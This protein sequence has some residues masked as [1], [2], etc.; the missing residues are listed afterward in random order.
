MQHE[1]QLDLRMERVGKQSYLLLRPYQR[2]SL[3]PGEPT[4]AESYILQQ[5]DSGTAQA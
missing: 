4:A 2:H 5:L 1:E 3:Y